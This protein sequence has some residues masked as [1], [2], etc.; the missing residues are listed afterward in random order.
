[1]APQDG[2][3]RDIRPDRDARPDRSERTG[4]DDQV[5]QIVFRW[6]AELSGTTG[7]GPVAW[8]VDRAEVEPLARFVG[9]LLRT[10]G[11]ATRPALVRLQHRAGDRAILIR[12]IPWSDPGGSP[13][14]ICHLLTG[15]PEL[16][17]PDNCLGLHAWNWQGADLPLDR[18]RGD[19]P[20]VPERVLLDATP[21]GHA[22]LDAGLGTARTE[23]VGAVAEFLRR[24]GY[25][26]TLRDEQGGSAL[27]V[28]W[29]LHGLF[30]ESTDFHWTFATHDTEESEFLRFIFV[31]RWSGQASTDGHR[32]RADPLHRVGDEAEQVAARLVDHHLRGVAAGDT[33]RY[34]VA[35]ALHRALRQ[36]SYAKP[37]ML[38]V[39]RAAAD[40]L[41]RTE[42]QRRQRSHDTATDTTA[43]TATDT[44]ADT[45]ARPPTGTAPVTAGDPA[46]KPTAQAPA[47][48]PAPW[49][50]AASHGTPPV[51]PYPATTSPATSPATPPV[52]SPAREGSPDRDW[53][54]DRD[55]ERQPVI[56]M[57]GPAETAGG[58]IGAGVQFADTIADT[59]ADS[60]WA[61]P[62]PGRRRVRPGRRR[63]G[64]HQDFSLEYLLREAPTAEDRRRWL[65]AADDR[66]LLAV[67]RA[68]TQPRA[69]V[70]LVVQAVAGRYSDWGR[71]LRVELCEVVIAAGYFVRRE[72]PGEPPTSP[73]RWAAD[74]AALHAW[75]V[76]PVLGARHGEAAPFRH[77]AAVLRR[78]GTSQDPVDR[79]VFRGL[80]GGGR[81]G[82]PEGV[83]QE[84]VLGVLPPDPQPSPQPQ[85]QPQPHHQP[86][87]HAQSYPQPQAA[88]SPHPHPQPYAPP[89][90]PPQPAEAPPRP[91]S[92]RGTRT[93]VPA[94]G[95]ARREG[96]R[97]DDGHGN[98]PDAGHDKDGVTTIALLG[99]VFVLLVVLIFIV[100]LRH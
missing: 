59:L 53:Q 79:A 43:D 60:P 84:V 88:Q 98:G 69:V 72:H 2:A 37:H 67:L 99:A 24:P 29:G 17:S 34:A 78:F 65:A 73:V 40:E 89:S 97:W 45:T 36:A 39:A 51:P 33:T 49:T 7:F 95:R 55:R 5:D 16:L 42:R 62:P 83:W 71:S 64:R 23:L 4:M 86:H 8:S 76:R 94:E 19:L 66:E 91:V 14:A 21:T 20:S 85:P 1:M 100:V 61:G 11:A 25:R 46:A 13:S 9:P 18:V 3:D 52:T 58:G 82:L 41:D 22:A 12:R 31:G 57:G 30:G 27:P 38:D 81:P 47:A 63:R 35:G 75:A 48:S 77:L 92:E 70:T 68:G 56:G 15:S 54:P 32:H 28:L 50:P 93:T 44:T 26:F 90:I 10:N 96:D 80:V 87:P 74:V 6:D